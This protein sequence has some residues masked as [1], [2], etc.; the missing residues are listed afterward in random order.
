[1]TPPK[2]VMA[3]QPQWVID[4]LV[5]IACEAIEVL[6]RE[7]DAARINCSGTIEALDNRFE[8]LLP[9]MDKHCVNAGYVN[10]FSKN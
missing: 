5:R 10:C 8:A 6:T 2:R 4:D 7:H 1:M 9:E 3:N